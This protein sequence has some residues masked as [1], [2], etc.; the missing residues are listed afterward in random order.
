VFYGVCYEELP[1][2][3]ERSVA[4]KIELDAAKLPP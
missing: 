1:A 2:C 3:E 4:P